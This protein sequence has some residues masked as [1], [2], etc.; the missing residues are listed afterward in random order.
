[1]RTKNKKYI[2][3]GL[4]ITILI[5][6]YYIFIFI[7]NYVFLSSI[8]RYHLVQAK[9]N[10]TND[11]EKIILFRTTFFTSENWLMPNL[12]NGYEYLKRINCPVSNCIFTHDK[13]YLSEPY[14]YDAIVFHAAQPWIAMD[15]PKTRSPHQSYVAVMLEAPPNIKHNLILD[16]NFYNLTMTY[17]FDSD[18]LWHYGKIVDA[19]TGNVLAPSLDVVWREPDEFDGILIYIYFYYKVIYTFFNF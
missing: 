8:A 13:N 1:M 5:T 4:L 15:L 3:M 14:L 12:T 6:L 16:H 9:K 7:Q 11:K 2:F 18:I 10:V 17:R 19:E